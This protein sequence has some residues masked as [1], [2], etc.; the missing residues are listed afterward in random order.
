MAIWTPPGLSHVPGGRSTSTEYSWQ[1][2]A[3]HVPGA[4]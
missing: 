2:S 4:W 1:P 3:A